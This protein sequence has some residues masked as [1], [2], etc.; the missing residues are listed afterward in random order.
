MAASM[1]E[2]VENA[3]SNQKGRDGNPRPDERALSASLHG[4]PFSLGGVCPR[5]PCESLRPSLHRADS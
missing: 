2:V 4:W 3:V 5:T 1:V